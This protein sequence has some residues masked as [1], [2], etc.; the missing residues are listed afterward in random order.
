MFSRRFLRQAARGLVAVLLFAQAAVALAACE[1][2]WRAPAQAI[3][4][5]EQ[6]AGD[7]R[8]HEE[9]ANVNLCV[10]HCLAGDQSTD[11]PSSPLPAAAPQP[12]LRI[13]PH[14]AVDSAPIAPRRLLHPHAAAPPR[15]LFASLL[16]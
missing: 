1:S 5:G 10:A 7:T 13:E 12:V 14:A 2:A 6:P 11:K 8:C 15:I 16:N 9:E 3:A 4:Q